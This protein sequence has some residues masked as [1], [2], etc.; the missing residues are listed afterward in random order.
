MLVAG[1]GVLPYLA[2]RAAHHREAAFALLIGDGLASP[3]QAS[4][5]SRQK[6]VPFISAIMTP[7][8]TAQS[9]GN[10]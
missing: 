3:R 1:G 6:P 10:E 8:A 7:T 5:P 2:D 4:R 9:S